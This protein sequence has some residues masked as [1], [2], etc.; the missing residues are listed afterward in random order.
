MQTGNVSEDIGALAAALRPTDFV[1]IC[2]AWGFVNTVGLIRST[3]QDQER[4][5]RSGDD[6]ARAADKKLKQPEGRKALLAAMRADIDVLETAEP[7]HADA[8]RRILRGLPPKNTATEVWY[9]SFFGDAG[10]IAGCYVRADTMDHALREAW[11]HNCNPGSNVAAVM[12]NKPEACRPG[13]MNQLLDAEGVK[14][15][16]APYRWRSEE[17]LNEAHL[18]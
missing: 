1:D 16:V 8:L 9:L 18:E 11:H 13:Y 10:W 7:E 3:T 15:A 2:Q 17:S 4:R 12:L 14:E 6:A 5:G